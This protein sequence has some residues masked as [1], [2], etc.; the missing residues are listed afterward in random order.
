MITTLDESDE[1]NFLASHLRRSIV[2][3]VKEGMSADEAKSRDLMYSL[4]LKDGIRYNIVGNIL[5]VG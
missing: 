1:K 2:G 5:G 4:Y 3:S